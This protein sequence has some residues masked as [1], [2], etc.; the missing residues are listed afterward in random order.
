ALELR[1][2]GQRIRVQQQPLQILAMLLERR[3]EVVTRDELRAAL[4]ASDVYVDFDRGL[5]KAMVKLREAIDDSA[6][7]PRFIE[8]LPKLGYRFLASE[9]T[10]QPTVVPAPR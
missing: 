9:E 8:T 2:Q 4:W 6:T 3:G 5:N 1:K 10:P 7:S